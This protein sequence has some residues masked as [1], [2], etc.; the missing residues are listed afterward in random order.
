MPPYILRLLHW[1]KTV[2]IL[3]VLSDQSH[4]LTIYGRI[5]NMRSFTSVLMS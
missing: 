5:S 1:C 3:T 4:Y 2:I